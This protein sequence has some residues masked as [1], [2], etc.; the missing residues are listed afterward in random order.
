MLKAE[1]PKKFRFFRFYIVKILKFIPAYFSI[2]V[3]N[4][5]IYNFN[6]KF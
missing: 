4:N 6:G 3:T 1:K 2:S 5:V